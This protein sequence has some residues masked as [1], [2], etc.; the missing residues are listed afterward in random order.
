[1][2]RSI[3]FLLQLSKGASIYG[4]Q[5]NKYKHIFMYSWSKKSRISISYLFA[6]NCRS[7]SALFLLIFTSSI[8]LLTFDENDPFKDAV[9]PTSRGGERLRELFSGYEYPLFVKSSL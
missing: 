9:A 6:S 7:D 8:S 2:F 4:Y 5:Q 1:M 3:Y